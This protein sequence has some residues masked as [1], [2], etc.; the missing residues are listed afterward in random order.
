MCKLPPPPKTAGETRRQS[1][2][3]QLLIFKNSRFSPD[4]VWD[5]T[6]EKVEQLGSEDDETV[7]ERAAL[8]KKLA[9]LEEGLKDLD[10]FTARS[11]A[12]GHRRYE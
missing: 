5:L 2:F 9:V 4:T 7:K 3:S 1:F 10:A 11:N 8:Q 12:T 6:E